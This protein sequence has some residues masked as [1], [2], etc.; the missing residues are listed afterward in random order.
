MRPREALEGGGSAEGWGQGGCRE[1]RPAACSTLQVPALLGASTEAAQ[2]CFRGETEAEATSTD[3]PSS[4]K[5]FTEL[6][7]KL[8]LPLEKSASLAQMTTECK[9]RE[10]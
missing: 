1:Q 2:T 5:P 9:L 3:G 6:S 8:R 4:D 10:G 7:G